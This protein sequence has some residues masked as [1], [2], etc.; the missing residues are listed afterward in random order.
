M[1]P[2]FEHLLFTADLNITDFDGKDSSSKIYRSQIP[3][4][5]CRQSL[6]L[7]GRP[8]FLSHSSRHANSRPEPMPLAQGEVVSA[9]IHRGCFVL[10]AGIQHRV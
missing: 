5:H 8:G 3:L 9:S 2:F 10:D 1:N 6:P 4:S 7:A